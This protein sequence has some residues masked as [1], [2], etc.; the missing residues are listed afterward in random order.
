[1][2]QDEGKVVHLKGIISILDSAGLLED[3]SDVEISEISGVFGELPLEMLVLFRKQPSRFVEWF[4]IWKSSL[5]KDKNLGNVYFSETFPTFLD[6]G[7][8]TFSRLIELDR[9]L[10]SLNS[11][12]GMAFLEKI[13]ELGLLMDQDLFDI[14]YP[15]VKDIA[16]RNWKAAVELIEHTLSVFPVLPKH[17]R[18]LLLLS[19]KGFMNIDHQLF[20][21]FFTG[22]PLALAALS[23][24]EF[25]EWSD[26][27]EELAVKN[28]EVGTL[29][30]KITPKFI[31]RIDISDLAEYVEMGK[32]LFSHAEP[33]AVRTFYEALFRGL[34]N[35]LRSS[36]R[37][38]TRYLLDIGVKLTN[39]CWRCVESFFENAP[40]MLFHLK[41]GDF[42]EWI[43]TGMSI[44]QSS[45]FY[46][47]DYFHTSLSVLKNTDRKYYSIIFGNAKLL[48]EKNGILAGIYFSVLSDILLNIH[49]KEIE[50]WVS[51]GLEVFEIDREMAFSF[52]R[53]SPSLLK[54]LEVTELAEWARNGLS[55]FEG[56]S[57]S[58]R[59][60]FSLRSK[61]AT[62]FAEKL[63]GGVALK[64]V[65]RVLKY[66][67]MGIS[68]INFTIRSKSFL[69]SEF[70]KYPNPIVSGR[71][72]YLEPTVKGYGDFEENFTIYKLSVMH[73]VGHIQFG[74]SAFELE[75]ILPL[76]EKIGI[77]LCDF[78]GGAGEDACVES[79]GVA[80]VIG[81]LPAPFIAADIMGIIEDARVEYMTTSL[82][83][84]LRREFEKVRMQMSR[85]RVPD[86]FGIE[87]FMEALLLSSVEIDP[88]FEIESDVKEIV[89]ISHEML[90]NNVFKP[91]SSTLDS[92]EAAI[93]IYSVLA[94]RFGPLKLLE[95][96]PIRNFAYRGM[97]IGSPF[98][99]YN[100]EFKGQ[101]MESFIPQKVL[102]DDEGL[103][104][105][106]PGKGPEYANSKNWEVLGSYSYDEWDSRMQ[107]YKNDWC[108]VYEVSPSGSDN[109][110]YLESREH[111]AREITL[112]NR[113]F[114]MMKPESFRK[115]RRQLDGD[116]FD[117]DALIEAF[118]DRKCGINPT[119]RLYIRRD[120]RERD[121]ATL[122]LLD[123]SASTRKKLEN[124]RRILD[125][126]KDSLI[127]MTQALES[128]GDNYAIAA[129][130]GNTRSDVEFYTIKE[131]NENFSEEAEC[132][133]SAL[134]PA[135]N[136]RLGAAI[137]HSTSKLKGID[138]KVKL[139]VL[140][141]DGDPY[142]LGFAE[143]KYEGQMAI[144]DTR[145][146]IQEGKA[147]GM[148]F[149][150][151]TVDTEAGEYLDAIF[152]DVGYTIIDNAAKLPERL[153]M[154]Y[155]RITS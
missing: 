60:Y 48:L 138:A 45:T 34:K 52:F 43:S 27:G 72:I 38:K 39:I 145:I 134:E 154:L 117:L 67:S 4:S 123:M 50:R 88:S 91:D 98:V 130:S 90:L 26:L 36:D 120:K 103:I 40:E 21:T 41:E 17:Q 150:C 84:G 46:G 114:K 29:F 113:I 83:R 37:E 32:E 101:A 70:S 7:S 57:G 93:S 128:I 66:Y 110:F 100:G 85:N 10:N 152:S 109:E 30:L 35:D 16:G 1:M 5:N 73:E 55:I 82:Y 74:T 92:L 14:W 105:D 131:F 132:K 133:I 11:S 124:G 6:F 148:H 77:D 86:V 19:S 54:D 137:R 151:I 24:T 28:G 89:D 64:R 59:S 95:Y 13:E 102:P 119:D 127:I 56:D 122:F 146:A 96:V 81:K 78:P 118:T 80:S 2:S 104:E 47:S 79:P 58:G 20:L 125:V 44:S 107:D 42:D 69:S 68:G 129:F 141:S 147:L 18:K 22:A 65:S 153:P 3:L 8:V 71:T 12:V 106:R 112:I 62:E 143:G 116:D 23:K 108:T 149:F 49:P 155:N 87:K 115:L 61:S 140:L 25:D 97:S 31:G 33:E 76:F 53:N 142:D 136:T 126:E 15:I 63:M 51:T 9:E 144:E 75:A 94:E 121:V 135:M 139:L 111:Y 99:T